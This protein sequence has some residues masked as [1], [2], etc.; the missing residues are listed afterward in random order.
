MRI[1]ILSTPEALGVAVAREASLRLNRAIAELG[2]ARLLVSTG[3]SQFET[4]R[5]LVSEPVDW[6][7]VE[8]FH[9][10]EY[11]GLDEAHPAS[12]RRYL[13]E[14]LTS[15]VPLRRAYFVDPGPG[16]SADQV[17]A[18]LS[19]AIGSRAIDVALIGIGE[20]AHIAFNDPPADFDYDGAYL[21][22]QLDEQ[23]KRQQ[24]REG[25]FPSLPDVPQAAISMSVRQIL[26]SR[27]ILCPVPHRQKAEAIR[28][29]LE[30]EE[31]PD[32]PASI[33][34]RHPDVTLY[35]DQE[36]SRLVTPP[37][38]SADALG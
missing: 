3:A 14:R 8:M 17:I 15:R 31:S 27:V 19:Q 20:N 12:F 36:S 22:V 16:R 28:R 10:D 5:A 35:L 32:V 24:V 18:E 23:C 29:T 30:S 25:W 11:I 6:S 13:R 7:R 37:A 4:L 2:S 26:R 21:V 9:L 38:T 34:K 33:L 1:E